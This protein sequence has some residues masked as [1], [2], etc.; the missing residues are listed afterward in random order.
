MSKLMTL[1][2]A[3]SAAIRVGLVSEVS[4]AISAITSRDQPVP[5][6]RYHRGRS[7]GGRCWDSGETRGSADASPNRAARLSYSS[8]SALSRRMNSSS[9]IA[10]ARRRHLAAWSISRRFSSFI[11]AQFSEGQ[12]SFGGEQVFLLRRSSPMSRRSQAGPALRLKKA[13][14]LSLCQSSTS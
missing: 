7:V 9:L 5:P 4:S 2:R 13:I 12:G 8:A 1:E 6:E 3:A 10:P 14:L 11:P